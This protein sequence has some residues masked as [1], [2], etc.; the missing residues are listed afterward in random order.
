MRKVFLCVCLLQLPVAGMVRAQ[1][2]RATVTGTVTDSSGRP[3]AG[4]EVTAK[5]LGTAVTARAV[6]NENGIYSIPNLFPRSYSLEFSKDG[7]KALVFPRVTLESTQ[8]AEMNATLQIGA[9]SER[10]TVT[11]EAPLLDQQTATIGTNMN[12]NVISDL[13]LNI[14]GG[15]QIESF[16]V[17]I[18]PGYSPSSSPYWAVI[19]GTQGFT[20]D[21]TVDGTS[22]T[23]QIQGDSMEIGPSMEAVQEMQAQTSGLSAESGITN[24]GVIAF[25]LKSGTNS[26]HGSAFGFGHNEFLDANTWD[27]NN[28]GSPRPKARFWNYGFSGGGPIRRDK[29]FV[30]GAFERFTQND[31]TPAGFGSAAT[32]PTQAFLAGDFS[33][34]LGAQL[35]TQS[36]GSVAANC[37]TGTTPIFVQNNNAQSVPLQAGMIFDPQ[38]GNQFTGNIIPSTRFSSVAQKI[39]PLYQKYYSPERSTLIQ[40]DRLPSSNS[41]AQTPNQAVIKIDHNLLQNDRLSGSWVYNHRPRTLVDS[42]GI[43]S[44]G[45]SDGGPLADSR[46]QLVYAHELRVSE[47]HIFTPTLMNVLN[48]TYNWYWNGSNPA[49]PG[50]SWSQTLGFGSTGAA[51][52]PVINFGAPVNGIQ[53]TSIGNSWQGHYVGATFILGDQ[54]MWNKG[55]HTFSLGGDFR[56][57]Q[58]NSTLGAGALTFNFSPDQTGAPLTPYGG[59][60]GFGFASFLLGGVHSAS[61]STAFNLYGRRKADSFFAS[62]NYKVTRKLTLNMGLRW[63]LTYP[64]HEKY[65]HWANF[66]LGAISSQLGIPGAMVYANGG[67]DSFEEMYSKN[68]APQFGAAYNPWQ[69]LVFRGSYGMLYAPLGIQYWQGVPYGFAPGF[70]GINRVNAIANGPAFNWDSGYPGVFVPGTKDP[71]NI[72]WG[73]VNIDPRNL[74]LGYTHNF[75]AGVQYALTSNT[76]IEAVYVGNRGRRLHDPDLAFN[77]PDPTRFLNLYNSSHFFDWVTD[78]GSAAA[79]GVPFPYPGFQG[80]AFQAIAPY[81]QITTLYSPIFYV[82]TPTGRSGYDSMILQVVKKTGR[83]L[84]MDFSYTLS[85]SVGDVLTNFGENWWN[86]SFQNFYSLSQDESTLTAFD[87]KHVFK[88]YFAYELPFGHGRPFL[89]NRGRLLNSLVG[90]WSVS[91]LF[92]YAS[93]NPLFFYSSNVRSDYAPWAYVWSTVYMNYNLAGYGGRKF[94]PSHFVL[95]S[96]Q[97]PTPATDLYFPASVVSD[98][99]PGTLGK[100]PAAIDQL[101]GFGTASEDAGILKYL[102]FGSEG[103]YA[104]SLRVEFYNLFNRHSFANPITDNTSS[105]FGYVT[106]VTG[107]PRQGQFGARFTF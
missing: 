21:V 24:G 28:A 43:W 45:S 74:R 12:G 82:G 60:V 17:A 2:N 6:T 53:E 40:N 37:G 11:A 39:L 95:P 4:V 58:I 77:Q 1:A 8:V 20:K 30:F 54:V 66:D 88:G 51:N 76:R 101:R 83:G 47:Q 50:Q 72:P 46:I 61:E 85:R 69:R 9:V 107:S 48:A 106:G 89:A 10:V 5:D 42:G 86:G 97:S 16:A 13:P 27:N 25:N 103:R 71:N 29:T 33:S 64:F 18:T 102:R 56:A 36:D 73:P 104:L 57:M 92:L 79:A 14:Y 38:T 96:I 22:A 84:T 100:G 94:D 44:P 62:D 49:A 7:F 90:G 26:L 3:V 59:Q 35:C 70:Q 68:L 15:R 34:L 91:G 67:G 41:P 19:N 81:P 98:P 99:V 87:Q 32:V 65:G 55:R 52:F 105:Q 75:N 80:F 63:D 78:T 93:G 23:A 31:F